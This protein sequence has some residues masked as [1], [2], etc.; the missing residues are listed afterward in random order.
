MADPIVF[1]V[2]GSLGTPEFWERYIAE[3]AAGLQFDGTAGQ[4]KFSWV[5]SRGRTFGRLLLAV[6]SESK[7]VTFNIV[8][9]LARKWPLDFRTASTDT[10][11]IITGDIVL[12][13]TEYLELITTGATAAMYATL[14]LKR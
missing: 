5:D 12:E 6:G 1:E 3:A 9:T 7:A 4:G 14:L 8:D 10:R 11:I 2:M 13:P